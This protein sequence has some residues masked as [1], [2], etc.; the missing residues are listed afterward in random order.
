MADT[1]S[2][3]EKVVKALAEQY[4]IS[5][6]VIEE[7]EAYQKTK[8]V[9]LTKALL[10]K[11]LI[12]E[13]ELLMLFAREMN[14]P[15]ID[16]NKY[17]IDPAL[18]EVVPESV[19]RQY[20]IVPLGLLDATL[21]IAVSDPLN[22][23]IIDD[24]RQITGRKIDVV[25][26]PSDE[27]AKVIEKYYKAPT[28]LGN[29]ENA[30][31]IEIISDKDNTDSDAVMDE[32]DTA[33]VVKMVNLIIKEAIKQRASDIHIEPMAEAVRVRYR[34]DGLLQEI[35]TVPKENQNAVIVRIKIMSRL[36]ITTFQ[37]PQ[38]GRFRLKL[39]HKD[40]DFRVSFLP[41]TFGQK[42]VMRVLDK[43]NLS[44]GL[45]GLGI[46][47]GPLKVMEEALKQPF[48]MILVTGPTGSGKSTTLYS[49]VNAL[50]VI[51]R[52]ITRLRRR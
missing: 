49:M 33:P 52:N 46:S 25:P 41:T 43:A 28:T 45:D 1:V 2:I 36:D 12:S 35:L 6:K 20:Q 5:S 44:V 22:V 32:S 7:V 29:E 51:E 40:V 34:I 10:E 17:K 14:I 16:L 38:H 8:G 31:E 30:E 37:A 23:V 26:C 48:G 9:S 19:A 3:K 24:L 50:N 18:Q 21:T 11:E 47:Q 39:A 13:K 15:F 27:I 4:Q 42:I